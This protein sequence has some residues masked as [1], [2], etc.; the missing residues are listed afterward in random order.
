MECISSSPVL[1]QSTN[2]I[3]VSLLDVDGAHAGLLDPDGLHA[4]PG[5]LEEGGRPV[6]EGRLRRGQA[7]GVEEV[8][9]RLVAH[10]IGM[11]AP[12]PGVGVLDGLGWEGALEVHREAGDQQQEGGE[13]AGLGGQGGPGPGAART[14]D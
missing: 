5:A 4:P 10:P 3:T 13:G 6:A 7:G 14:G 9:G 11:S 2:R 12:G 1:W 8:V